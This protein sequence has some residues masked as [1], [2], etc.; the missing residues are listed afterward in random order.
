MLRA[1]TAA[2]N[3]HTSGWI[4]GQTGR[5]IEAAGPQLRRFRGR[6]SRGCRYQ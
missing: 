4:G 5:G 1:F 6:T 3:D 2:N